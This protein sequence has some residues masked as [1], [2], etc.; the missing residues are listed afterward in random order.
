MSASDDRRHD[1]FVPD[2]SPEKPK[3]AA[4]GTALLLPARRRGI[5]LE[6]RVRALDEV[7]DVLRDWLSGA[8]RPDPLAGATIA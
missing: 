6:S 2:R 8:A 5:R 1:A 7:V 3:I 4:L